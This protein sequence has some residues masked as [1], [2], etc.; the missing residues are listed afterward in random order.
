M[1]F[2]IQHAQLAQALP[3]WYAEELALGGEEEQGWLLLRKLDLIM[4]ISEW[5]PFFV[6]PVTH[7]SRK[8][9]RAIHRDG[10]CKNPPLNFY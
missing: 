7:P 5:E 2:P 4:S 8:A 9:L 1:S 3:G 10:H 6:T